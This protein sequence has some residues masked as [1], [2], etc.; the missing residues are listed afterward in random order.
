[1]ILDPGHA[2]LPTHKHVRKLFKK[3]TKQ[4]KMAGS[5]M[6]DSSDWR[7]SVQVSRL[8]HSANSHLAHTHVRRYDSSPSTSTLRGKKPKPTRQVSAPPLRTSPAVSVRARSCASQLLSNL[9]RRWGANDTSRKQSSTAIVSVTSTSTAMAKAQPMRLQCLDYVKR[10]TLTAVA[11]E[12]SKQR[13]VKMKDAMAKLHGEARPGASGPQKTIESVWGR[14]IAQSTVELQRWSSRYRTEPSLFDKL[15]DQHFTLTQAI[16][17][18]RNAQLALQREQVGCGFLDHFAFNC[19]WHPYSG[20]YVFVRTNN[21][22][23]G[24]EQQVSSRLLI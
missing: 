24:T 18:E 14:I 2:A 8:L 6:I 16:I 15:V 9:T 23:I 21:R 17:E 13:S 12:K 11:A 7:A 22:Q 1:M 5:Q 19:N 4:S 10:V 20:V 3:V